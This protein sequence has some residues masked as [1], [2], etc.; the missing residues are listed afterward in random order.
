[1]SLNSFFVNSSGSLFFISGS[2][3]LSS[4]IS[5]SLEPDPETGSLL[6]TQSFITTAFPDPSTNAFAVFQLDPNDPTSFLITGS[7]ESSFYMSSSGKMGFGTDDPLVA[8]DIRADEFQIQKQS[9]RQGIRVND[10]GNIESFNGETDAAAT[11]SEFI[12]SYSR[13]GAS[14]LNSTF[15]QSLG[16]GADEISDA[17]GAVAFFNSRKRRDQD[18]ILFLLERTEGLIDKA[19]VGDVLGSIRW[20]AS[21]GS[22]S[23]LYSRT[24]G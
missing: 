23:K 5:T 10:E 4:S 19:S 24:A 16:F 7:E 11:G 12:L 2:Y 3:E 21:S 15:L 13:G 6:I 20:V 17:G 1:M 8:F 22:I 14:K 18:K 9:K